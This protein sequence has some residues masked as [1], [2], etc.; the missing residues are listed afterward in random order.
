MIKKDIDR[1]SKTVEVPSIIMSS[2]KLKDPKNLANT[3]Q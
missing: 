3:L 1:K 2:E